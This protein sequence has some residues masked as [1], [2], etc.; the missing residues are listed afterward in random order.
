MNYYEK[1]ILKDKYV[2]LKPFEKKDITKEF[3]SFL[4]NKSINK[5][6][7]SRKVQNKET[8]IEYL[9]E[10]KNNNNYY[11]AIIDRKRKKLIGTITIRS[12]G[13]SAAYIGY[14]VGKKKYHGSKQSDNSITMALDF[15]FKSL[16]FKKIHAGTEKNNI[17]ANFN[18]VKNDFLLKKK[19][20]NTF[21]FVLNKKDFKKKIKYEISKF[22]SIS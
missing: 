4:N 12:I 18:M 11:W 6:L 8:A 13:K 20:M 3:L 17:S 22:N 10:I 21:H 2:T 15:T 14:M 5:Y 19:K 1:F 16:N 7:K 9:N